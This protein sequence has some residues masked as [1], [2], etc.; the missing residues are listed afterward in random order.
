[1]R[2]FWNNRVAALILPALLPACIA[3]APAREAAELP[4]PAERKPTLSLLLAAEGIERV[5]ADELLAGAESVS[6]HPGTNRA[7]MFGNEQ[8]EIAARAAWEE[9]GLFSAISHEPTPT[10]DIHAFVML[11]C[12]VSH[13]WSYYPF[14]LTVGLFPHKMEVGVLSGAIVTRRGSGLPPVTDKRLLRGSVWA[15]TLLLIAGAWRESPGT[16]LAGL[17]AQAQR[18]VIARSANLVGASPAILPDA[19][20]D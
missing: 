2:S 11:R 9:S 13:G 16:A 1:M 17:A 4:Q 6:N 14:G 7:C 3:I 10:G 8:V 20:G 5:M 12:V 19:S 15:Q 18:E